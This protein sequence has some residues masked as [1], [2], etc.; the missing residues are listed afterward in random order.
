[1]KNRE[2]TKAVKDILWMARRYVNDRQTYAPRMFNDAY[3]VLR[4]ELGEGIETPSEEKHEFLNFPYATDGGGKDF[5]RDLKFRPFYKSKI[6]SL[7]GGG[8]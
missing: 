3:D 2:I 5:N 1:M 7:Q 6:K 4:C 8:K